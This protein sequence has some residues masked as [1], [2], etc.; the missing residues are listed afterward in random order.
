MSI[1]QLADGNMKLLMHEP[2]IRYAG[3]YRMNWKCTMTI[4]Y[5]WKAIVQ[6][7]SIV[8]SDILAI[9]F[10]LLEGK[11]TMLISVL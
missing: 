4:R 6:A 10:Y 9:Q 11:L 2:I 8:S 1:L 5:G 7:S 3:G